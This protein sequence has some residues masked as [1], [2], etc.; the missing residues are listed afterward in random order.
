MGGLND[1]PNAQ[2]PHIG[3]FGLRNA[4]KSSLVNA[5]TGQEL[6]IVSPVPGT[7]TDPVQKAMELLPLGPV[8]I[9]D[10]PGLDDGG[11][12]G[13]MRVEKGQRMLH[14]TDVAVLVIDAQKGETDY[15]RDLIAQI[16]KRGIPYI[17]AM[18]KAELV[19]DR[20][21]LESDRIWVSAETG[22]GIEDLKE[23]IAGLALPTE[24]PRRLIGDLIERGDTVILV[25]PIDA[26]AP[27]GRL[28]LPQQQTIRDIL[29]AGAMTMVV[30]PQELPE[31]LKSL[32]SAPR[33][34]VTDSQAFEEVDAMLPNDIPLTSFS[35]LFVRLKGSLG[36][37]AKGAF[38][39]DSL[40]DGDTVL[41][42]EGCSH[43]RQCEDIGTIKMPGWITKYTG[44]D[45]NFA[46]TSGGD[47]PKDLSPYAL[48][49][50][51]GACM[52][53][54]RE[55]KYRVAS[56]F[57]AGVPMTNYG[58]AIAKMHGILERAIKPLPD[59]Q[60]L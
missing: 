42:S 22:E 10:T 14:K 39:L 19:S 38:S 58:I 21:E 29:E 43:H 33:L 36:E 53:N 27:K 35:I 48:I 30:Q 7:T 12:L 44:K 9:I 6:A 52:L 46:F 54:D 18:N 16:K 5:V 31:A 56:A 26:S 20:P 3:F 60:N 45:I 55:M 50:H 17:I 2:R 25:T 1:Q 49:V 51:C 47:F 15:D 34:V 41:I 23:K 28:I 40:K 32:A 37:A 24:N 57:E 13:A 8:V 59:M 4:G 11:D